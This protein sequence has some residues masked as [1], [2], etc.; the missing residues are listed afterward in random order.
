MFAP[1]SV[2]LKNGQA[3]T[4]RRAK[5]SDAQALVEHV[6]D[7]GAEEV[8][9]HTE[10]LSKSVE[11]ERAFLEGLDDESALFLVAE[12]HGKLVGSADVVRGRHSKN[13]HTA[14]LGIALR[15]ETRGLGLGTAMMQ[16]SI[17]WARAIGIRK[18]TL[19]VF[20]TNT[21][22]RK[23]YGNLGFKEEG[24]LKG[25]VIL[26]GQPDDEIWMSLWL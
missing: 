4:M 8:Y 13:R 12:I 23:L 6:N 10:R 26:R 17:D 18:L 9:I 16:A 14:Q 7:V 19:G 3:A 25:Q 21:V 11:E 1:R 2:T 20:A 15:K 22:A 24:R 5:P